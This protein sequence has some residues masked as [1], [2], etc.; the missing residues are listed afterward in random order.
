MPTVKS[1]AKLKI[2]TYYFYHDE[3]ILLPDSPEKRYNYPFSMMRKVVPTFISVFF[4][5]ISPS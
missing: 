3:K 5:K 4:T 1:S 2:L